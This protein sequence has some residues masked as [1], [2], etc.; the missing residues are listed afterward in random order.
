MSASML[1]NKLTK[2]GLKIEVT[3]C[4][5]EDIPADADIVVTHEG[6]SERAKSMAPHAE[7]I[8][9]KNFVNAPEYDQLVERFSQK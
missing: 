6:L 2:A 3:N 8:S 5:I 1:R 9:I 7:H 4:A